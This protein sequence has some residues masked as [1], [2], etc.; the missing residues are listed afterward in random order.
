MVARMAAAKAI[1]YYPN[2]VW[3]HGLLF[4]YLRPYV[5]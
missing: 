4:A 1:G 3:M 2:V 5:G